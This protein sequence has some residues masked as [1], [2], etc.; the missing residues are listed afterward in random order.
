MKAYEDI[1]KAGFDQ[2]PTGS[3]WSCDE[4][5]AGP[6]K[7]CRKVCSPECLKGFMMAPWFFT[8]PKW[9]Q[10]NLKAVDLVAEAMA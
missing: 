3:N 4:N 6:V 5:F 8:L 2:V 10:K 9:E 1:D 7:H